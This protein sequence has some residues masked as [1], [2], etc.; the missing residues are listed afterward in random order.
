MAAWQVRPPRLVTMAAAVFITGSP[1]GRGGVG[2]QH[3]AGLELGEVARVGHAPHGAA[4]D[5]RADGAAACLDVAFAVEHEFFDLRRLA[6][7]AAVSG[8][9]CTM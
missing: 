7:Q 2:H 6:L 8:R 4:G 1:V 3:L 5:A 9:A